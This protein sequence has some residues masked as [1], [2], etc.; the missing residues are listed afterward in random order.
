VFSR[1]LSLLIAAAYL[2]GQFAALPHAHGDQ[3]E[4]HAGILHIHLP[5]TAAHRHGDHEHNHFSGGHRHP[6]AQGVQKT[7]NPAP[8]D[9]DHGCIHLPGGSLEST[10][11]KGLT[12][13]AIDVSCLAASGMTAVADTSS[14]ATATITPPDILRSG[15]DLCVTLRTWR[16]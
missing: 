7:P 13:D 2:V 14:R 9:H 10:P 4:G 16:I 6:P 3:R 11:G 15:R 8:A 1:L 5:T 12:L